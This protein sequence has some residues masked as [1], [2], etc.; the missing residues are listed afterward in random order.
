MNRSLIIYKVEM[1]MDEIA[2]ALTNTYLID[3][4]GEEIAEKLVIKYKTL[5]N[6]IEYLENT[7]NIIFNF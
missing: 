2:M 7:Y 3:K 1:I 6:I 5:D 4:F